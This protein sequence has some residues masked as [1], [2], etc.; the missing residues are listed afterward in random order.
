MA[1]QYFILQFIKEK[2]KEIR[3]KSIQLNTTHRLVTAVQYT[4]VAIFVFVILEILITKQYHLI[5]LI[6]ATLISYALNVVLLILFAKR[7]LKWYRSNR[8]SIVII[9]YSISALAL[10]FSS[11]VALVADYRNLIIKEEV[12]TPQSPIIFPSF[13]PGTLTSLLSDIYRHSNMIAT[14][15]VWSTTVLLLYHYFDRLN[16][17]AKGKVLDS[18]YSSFDILSKYIF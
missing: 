8:N 4:L 12:I 14:L 13:D 15:L 7:L 6:A 16:K 2:T 17:L 5:N 3:S 1:G 18:Y 11:S 10:A 9:L